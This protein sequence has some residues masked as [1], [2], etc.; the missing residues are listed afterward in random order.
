ME[1]AVIVHLRQSLGDL[2]SVFA[3]EDKLEAAIEKAEA[4]RFDGNEYRYIICGLSHG[5]HVSCIY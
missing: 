3:L 4:G 5:S 1:H 2:A